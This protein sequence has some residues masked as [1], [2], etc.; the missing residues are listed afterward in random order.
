MWL[1][2]VRSVTFLLN[3]FHLVAFILLSFAPHLP[4]HQ[5]L[6]SGYPRLSSSWM[7]MTDLTLFAHMF[8]YAPPAKS[9]GIIAEDRRR[10]NRSDEDQDTEHVTLIFFTNFVPNYMLVFESK[11]AKE[12]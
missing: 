9:H 7:E 8:K 1:V 2:S 11:N 10:T 6:P 4:S 3:A 5:L 12:N